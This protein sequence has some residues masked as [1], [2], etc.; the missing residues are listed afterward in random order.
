MHTTMRAAVVAA[1]RVAPSGTVHRSFT[2]L[3]PQ[4][5]W[6]QAGGEADG[7][8]RQEEEDDRRYGPNY[9]WLWILVPTGYIAYTC[10]GLV[11]LIYDCLS[12]D[13][14]IPEV[15]D[16]IS[17]IIGKYACGP[18]FLRLAWQCSCLYSAED[19]HGSCAAADLAAGAGVYAQM[20]CN[21]GVNRAIDLLR[22]VKAK[23]P[24]LSWADLVAFAG[25]VAVQELGGPRVTFRGGRKDEPVKLD[26]QRVM[27]RCPTQ[28]KGI[29]HLKSTFYRMGFSKAELTALMGA[30]T[31]GGSHR[32]FS[33]ADGRRSFSPNIFDNS[34]FL[35]LLDG[36]WDRSTRDGEVTMMRRGELSMHP[37]DLALLEDEGLKKWVQRFAHDELFFHDTFAEAFQKLVEL[38]HDNLH[39]TPWRGISNSII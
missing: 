29:N 11:K 26:M 15:G 8:S 30:H 35:D 2:R 10:S 34:Y 28:N 38:G 16:D 36:A 22:P 5:R 25:C 33:G 21:K 19:G 12:A 6:N 1:R 24:D 17:T 32:V 27:R 39:G 23:Y 7:R 18:L 9:L 13:I 14:N 4:Q 3:R 31:V 37:I 20:P